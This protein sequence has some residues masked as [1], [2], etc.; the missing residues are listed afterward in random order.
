MVFIVKIL[1]VI[2]RE[3]ALSLSSGEYTLTGAG[4][5]Q[6]IELGFLGESVLKRNQNTTVFD[7]TAAGIGIGDITHLVTRN[8]QQ[9]RKQIPVLIG[10][11]QHDDELRVGDHD[12]GFGRMQK[13]G[14]IL[15]NGRGERTSLTEPHPDG[16]EELG[17]KVILEHSMELVDEDMSALTLLPVQSG[18]VQ[19]RVRN[20]Q[21]AGSFQV[22][23]QAMGVENDD[24]LAQIHNAFPAIDVQRTGS[25]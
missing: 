20:N 22:L 8:F 15:G 7:Q 25:K 13:I 6:L 21:Q 9:R 17:G 23:A 1:L 24:S 14:Y 10:L 11:A 3:Q 19:N 4:G 18:S 16:S 12:T 2:E 5:H